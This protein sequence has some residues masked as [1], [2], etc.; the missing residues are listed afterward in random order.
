[1][2]SIIKDT[3]RN[4]GAK[5]TTITS[6][7]PDAIFSY[8]DKITFSVNG[9]TTVSPDYRVIIYSNRSFDIDNDYRA[10]DT[11]ITGQEI[12]DLYQFNFS[13][14]LT[15]DKGLYYLIIRRD[16]SREVLHISRFTVE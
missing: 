9:N 14:K 13:G 15:L 16:G 5:K 4:D 11:L 7:K 3:Y 6:P 8:A 12:N 10:L 1:M 2:E